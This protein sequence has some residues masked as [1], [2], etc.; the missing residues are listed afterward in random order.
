MISKGLIDLQKDGIPVVNQER[1]Y[2]GYQIPEGFLAQ[3][4]V[5]SAGNC[6]E[7]LGITLDTT[8]AVDEFVQNNELL[9][10][11][12]YIVAPVPVKGEEVFNVRLND[13]TDISKYP[14]KVKDILRSILANTYIA[15][16]ADCVL[17]GIENPHLIGI[18]YGGISR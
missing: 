12:R 10:G 4:K 9:P 2:Y 16:F 7:D 6:I 18:E 11:Q 13:E 15:S 14:D 1:Y 5:E 8:E 3:I 17:A